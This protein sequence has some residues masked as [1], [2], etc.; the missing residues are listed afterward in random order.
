MLPQEKRILLPQDLE[1]VKTLEEY[2]GI[3]GLVGLQKA[4]AEFEAAGIAPPGFL[5]IVLGPDD[6]LFGEEKA[7]LF[8]PAGIE[9]HYQYYPGIP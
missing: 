4:A 1:P 6:Y 7:L 3:G 2:K 8:I 9:S 5:E